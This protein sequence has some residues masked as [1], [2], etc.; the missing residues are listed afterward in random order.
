MVT[1]RRIDGVREAVIQGQRVSE[2]ELI[3]PVDVIQEGISLN[4][5]TAALAITGRDAEKEV[6]SAIARCIGAGGAPEVIGAVV[7]CK[8]GVGDVEALALVAEL[9]DVTA[10]DPGD[11]IIELGGL[12]DAGLGTIA[13]EAQAKADA[14]QA[15]HVDSGDSLALGVLRADGEAD[16]GGCDHFLGLDGVKV[17]ARVVCGEIVDHRGA[18]VVHVVGGDL[19][20]AGGVLVAESGNRRASE[21]QGLGVLLWWLMTMP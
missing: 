6:Q 1:Q 18:E 5:G 4:I 17:K 9:E 13:A 8:E 10:H 21:G 20:D 16:A 19:I 7:V 3:L 2:L 11:G 15:G 14:V 12:V